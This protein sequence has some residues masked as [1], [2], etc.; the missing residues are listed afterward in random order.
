MASTSKKTMEA[1]ELL[2]RFSANE[3]PCQALSHNSMPSAPA[4]GA[5]KPDAIPRPED[6]AIAAPPLMRRAKCL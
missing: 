1:I 2:Y 4:A 5:A 6:A 3:L